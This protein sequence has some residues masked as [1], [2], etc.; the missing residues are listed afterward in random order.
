MI[1]SVP[2]VLSVARRIFVHPMRYVKPLF[3]QQTKP[4]RATSKEHQTYSL[5][6]LEPRLPLYTKIYRTR[7]F[8]SSLLSCGLLGLVQYHPSTPV[9]ISVVRCLED[10]LHCFDNL[11]RLLVGDFLADCHGSE[12]RLVLCRRIV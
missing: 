12:S 10:F 6:L 7:R 5:A 9:Y 3:T 2:S 1:F 4:G 8:S 11:T